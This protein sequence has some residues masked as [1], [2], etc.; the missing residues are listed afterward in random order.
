MQLT[1]CFDWA[2][3]LLVLGCPEN[4]VERKTENKYF[5]VDLI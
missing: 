3:L 4:L 2:S 1:L 5:R